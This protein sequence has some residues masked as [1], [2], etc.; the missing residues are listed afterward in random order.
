MCIV[1]SIMASSRIIKIAESSFSLK[2]PKDFGTIK[3]EDDTLEPTRGKVIAI[4]HDRTRTSS[5]INSVSLEPYSHYLFSFQ[6]RS[7]K[8]Y[9][10]S[11]SGF[12][13]RIYSGGKRIGE[14]VTRISDEWKTVNFPVVTGENGKITFVTS[15]SA[16]AGEVFIDNVRL[17]K[18]TRKTLKRVLGSASFFPYSTLLP[19][20]NNA[21]VIPWYNEFPVSTRVVSRIN[22]RM[23]SNLA[24]GVWENSRSLKLE[25]PIELKLVSP[26]NL[27]AV[28]IS[29]G[30]HRYTLPQK[31]I[32]KFYGNQWWSTIVVAQ[33]VPLGKSRKAKL[34][35]EWKGGK[36]QTPWK[37]DI[38]EL[39]IP[40]YKQ[41]KKVIT[42]TQVHD[43]L[44]KHYKNKYPEIVKSL[45]FN[46]MT[47]WKL[48]SYNKMIPLFQKNGIK[49]QTE[50]SGRSEYARI[51]KKFPD[52]FSINTS[53]KKVAVINP[54]HRGS[55]YEHMLTI[56]KR[57]GTTGY[58]GLAI[59]D[60]YYLSWRGPSVDMSDKTKNLWKR[61]LSQ[62]RPDL[63]YCAPEILLDDPLNYRE[64]YYA[65]WMFKAS[66]TTKWYTVV[67]K[68]FV[69]GVKAAGKN[70]ETP[71]MTLEAGDATTARAKI[72][73][74]HYRDLLDVFDYFSPQLYNDI[75]TVRKRIAL[76]VKKVGKNRAMP[77]LTSGGGHERWEWKTGELRALIFEVLFA[78]AKGYDFWGSLFSNLRIQAEIALT[79]NA[80]AENEDIFVNGKKTNAFEI[81]NASRQFASV[82]ETDKSGLLLL[83]NYTKIEGKNILQVVKNRSEEYLLTEVFSGQKIKLSKEQTFFF[84]KVEPDSCLLFRWE[85]Q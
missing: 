17:K 72:D 61:W 73:A 42:G 55:L 53:G 13:L 35:V 41:P 76:L 54:A 21:Y 24:K 75:P 4:R 67:R 29:N 66:F 16:M 68:A 82:L 56:I 7:G 30:Y 46:F 28:P 78:G 60:E 39:N 19:K 6:L 10:V 85:K 80:V 74:F 50:H 44:I 43:R 25:L 12:V 62:N 52:A 79:N 57:L 3:I 31:E 22:L 14:Y 8:N 49:V 2:P 69:D 84:V 77:L 26:K 45:G 71:W 48:G 83:S 18:C 34:W 5:I 37:M 51:I 20:K 1:S 70:K 27:K 11:R 23:R 15:L 38:L 40:V 59:D 65:W 9:I 33:S 36:Q 64:Q 63:K 32:R 81:E 47:V 58:A